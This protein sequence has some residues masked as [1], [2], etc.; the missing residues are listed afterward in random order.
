M[1][2]RHAVPWH[3]RRLGASTEYHFLPKPPCNSSE[4]DVDRHTEVFEEAV[5]A[6]FA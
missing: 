3:A 2:R 5:E 4:Q 1:L 6:L